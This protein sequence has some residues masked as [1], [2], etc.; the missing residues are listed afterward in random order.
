MT[1][2]LVTGCAGFIGSHLTE[3]L[4]A[5]GFKVRGID[6]FDPYYSVELKKKN[7]SHF[8]NHPKFEFIEDSI[9]N[10]AILEALL[11]DVET[12]YHLAAVA[13]VR[14]SIKDPVK[15][16]NYDVLATVKLLNATK[17]QNVRKFVYASSSSV[18]GEV[19]ASE[20]PVSEKRA[21]KPI[22]PYGMAKLQ[23]EQWCE[24]FTAT[25]GL[26]TICLRFFTVY[27]PRQRPDEAFTKFIGS[28]LRGEEIVVYGDGTQTRD[29]TYVKDA[30][31]AIISG[32]NKG[33]GAYNIA[34]GKRIILNDVIKML[35]KVS[36]LKAKVKYVERKKEDVS[37]TWADISKA[38][39]ELGYKPDTSL[40][41]GIRAQT[42]WYKKEIL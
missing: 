35:E 31:N 24:M 14:N 40:E 32:A 4:L 13:G 27:G 33:K 12:V 5:R 37:H 23:G 16:C 8:Q 18:Y 19:P 41:H 42:E 17:N 7:L 20:L 29:F 25:Y 28:I 6:N 22:S 38:Q 26:P 11:K 30:V 10:D 21:L 36:E 2:V 39:K 15:Y 1:K 3:E 34:S 9:L